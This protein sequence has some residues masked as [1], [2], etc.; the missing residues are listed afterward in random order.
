VPRIMRTANG[1]RDVLAMPFIVL[2]GAAAC[3]SGDGGEATGAQTEALT[4]GTVDLD[5][6]AV[7]RVEGGLAPCTGTLIAGRVVLTAAHCVELPPTDVFFGTDAAGR[8]D[9]VGVIAHARHPAFDPIRVTNDV[10]LILLARSPPVPPA[11]WTAGNA[12]VASWIGS[13]VRLVGFGLTTPGEPPPTEKRTGTARILSADVEELLLGADRSL[14]CLGDS[15]GPL[16]VADRVIGVVS[17]GDP[18]C[19]DHARAVVL[20]AYADSFITPQLDAWDREAPPRG[21]CSLN[22]ERP[23]RSEPGWCALLL[24]AAFVVRLRRRR[25]AVSMSGDLRCGFD[26]P[27]G[28]ERRRQLRRVAR[29]LHRGGREARPPAARRGW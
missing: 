5:D 4:A 25:P 17:T 7:V 12:G 16:L 1:R 19:S 6:P 20:S 11:S 13:D 9:R 14:P 23:E 24:V 18:D 10:A 29:L 27:R 26:R 28:V 22:S 2:A 8:G 3:A 21:G 15:G